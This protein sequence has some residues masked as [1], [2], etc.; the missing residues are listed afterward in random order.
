MIVVWLLENTNE[1]EESFPPPSV[2]EAKPIGINCHCNIILLSG[3]KPERVS[4]ISSPLQSVLEASE[5]MAPAV[6]IPLHCCA[7]VP[8]VT[9]NNIAAKQNESKMFFMINILMR[10]QREFFNCGVKMI[11][12]PP[13]TPA[14][15]GH[16]FVLTIQ[17]IR[18]EIVQKVSS[19]NIPRWRGQGVA[20]L[21]LLL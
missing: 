7:C 4:R 17:Q 10:K 21:L 13:P 12:F 19:G 1:A 20:L 5:E 3:V 6:G 14:S 16:G 9:N 8:L 18:K 2:H 15:G 11:N